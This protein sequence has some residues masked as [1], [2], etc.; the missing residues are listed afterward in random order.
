MIDRREESMN[1]QFPLIMPAIDLMDG[2]CVRLFQG[3][4]NRRTVYSDDPA[5]MAKSFQDAGIRLIHL[6]DLDGA[7]AGTLVNLTALR[8][9]RSVVGCR[10]EIGGGI[11]SMQD[12]EQLDAI[13][14]E[15]F[16]L[17]SSVV[18]DFP[19]LREAVR[20]YGPQRVIVGIDMK[21]GKVAIKG[22]KD[23]SDI[24]LYDLLSRLE[25]VG[26]Q[27]IIYTDIKRDGALVGPNLEMVQE[28]TRKTR[29]KIVVSGGISGK[30]DV[31]NVKN[32]KN[33]RIVGIIIGKALY[34]KKVDLKDIV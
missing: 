25:S 18:Q 24:P 19:F 22:W 10:L 29:L 5:A 6:V 14:I 12:L 23:V 2:K 13:G 17:G 21:E 28:I 34:E 20:K 4:P 31:D 16:V 11:R 15:R 32:L 7:F 26:V 33:D 27:E 8:K 30:N 3:D 1:T 9:I